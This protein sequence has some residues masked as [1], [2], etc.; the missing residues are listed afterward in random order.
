VIFQEEVDKALGKSQS[1]SFNDLLK[2]RHI[3]RVIFAMVCITVIYMISRG[4][5]AKIQVSCIQTN[6][7]G[8]CEKLNFGMS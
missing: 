4:M 8:V 5:S 1:I 7:I 6:D 2:I 3:N